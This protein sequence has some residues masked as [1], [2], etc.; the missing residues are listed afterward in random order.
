[1]LQGE[2]AQSAIVVAAITTIGTVAASIIAAYQ[3]IKAK[4]LELVAAEQQR[5]LEKSRKAADELKIAASLPGDVPR[6]FAAEAAQA[7]TVRVFRRNYV[8]TLT[9]RERD[10]GALEMTVGLSFTLVNHTGLDFP[11]VHQIELVPDQPEDVTRIL[12]VAAVGADLSAEYDENLEPARP[13]QL[14]FMRVVNVR[15]NGSDPRNQFES[16][17]RRL[18]RS[19]DAEVLFFNYPTLGAEVRIDR[20]TDLDVT[21]AFSH[22]DSERM[23]TLPRG[24]AQPT[25]WRLDRAFLAWQALYVQWNKKDPVP[26]VTE[27]GP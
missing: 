13:G 22:R 14:E 26:S 12:R 7:G 2:S 5:A 4:R 23:E 18:T 16:R 19:H 20:P 17:F 27:Q 9:F 6:E 11:Y 21:V 24:A 1:M 15:P 8:V 10:A 3:A 25:R